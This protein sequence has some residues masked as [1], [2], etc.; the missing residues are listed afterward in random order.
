MAEKGKYWTVR[1]P[2]DILPGI[3]A[4]VGIFYYL[5]GIIGRVTSGN[6]HNRF[7][8][9]VFYQAVRPSKNFH[10]I[11]PLRGGNSFWALLL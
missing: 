8:F 4:F 10:G 11:P 1:M 3:L 5:C 9:L 2:L 6:T 7:R